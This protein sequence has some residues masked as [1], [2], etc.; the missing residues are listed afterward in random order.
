VLSVNTSNPSPNNKQNYAIKGVEGSY[1]HVVLEFKSH[2]KLVLTTATF[3][4]LAESK[5]CPEKLWT[6]IEKRKGKAYVSEA[7][8]AYEAAENK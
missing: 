2:G 6:S 1:G 5:V 4:D 8:K 7:K 3:S